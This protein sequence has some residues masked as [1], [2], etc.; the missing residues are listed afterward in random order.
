MI[1]AMS[2]NR[3]IGKDNQ[4]PWH[5][6]ADLAHFKRTTLGKAVLMGRKTFES[7]GHPLPGRRNIVISRDFDYKADGI[8]LI[9]SIDQ[10]YS[11]AESNEIDELFIIGGGHLYELFLPKV[12]RLYLTKI[13]ID[14]DGD[15]YFPDFEH[16]DWTLLESTCHE[17]DDKNEHPYCFE[18]WRRY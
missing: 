11:T 16:K 7:I 12:N 3:V 18:F 10:L 1:A 14:V 5:L 4:I 6:P 17:P 2:R 8:E 13:D 15:T 9:T